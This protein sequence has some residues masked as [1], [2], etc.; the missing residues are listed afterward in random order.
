MNDIVRSVIFIHAQSHKSV[1]TPAP[2]NRKL[3]QIHYQARILELRDLISTEE[4]K[5]KYAAYFTTC[6]ADCNLNRY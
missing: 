6:K 5:F 2:L 1:F 3:A 4:Q